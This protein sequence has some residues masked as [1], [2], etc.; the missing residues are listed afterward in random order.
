MADSEATTPELPK[1]VTEASTPDH[2]AEASTPHPPTGRRRRLWFWLAMAA[3]GLFVLATAG[4]LVAF[5]IDGRAHNGQIL[6][7][8]TLVLNE[9]TGDQLAIGGLSAAD[10]RARLQ[11]LASEHAQRSVTWTLPTDP[12]QTVTAT[13]AELDMGLDVEATLERA[14]AAGRTG[15]YITRFEAWL[16]SF[17]EPRTVDAAYFVNTSSDSPA[18]RERKDI[19]VQAPSDPA[20]DFS[21]PQGAINFAP[22]QTGSII[23]AADVVSQVAAAANPAA[24]SIDA[25]QVK[26]TTTPPRFNHHQLT[27]QVD[28]I[29]RQTERGLQVTSPTATHEFS[30]NQVRRWLAIELELDPASELNCETLP[31]YPSDAA[32]Q[33]TVELANPQEFHAELEWRFWVDVIPGTFGPIVV[34]DETPTAPFPEAGFRCCDSFDTDAVLHAV[35]DD[36][37]ETATQP[38]IEVPFRQDPELL[39]DFASE[40]EIQVIVG[41]F[42]TMHKPNESRVT[43]IQRFADLLRG[44]IIEPGARLSLNEHVGERTEENGFVEAGAINKGVFIESVGGGISQF[45]TTFF[46]AAFFAGLEFLEYQSHSLYL[47]RYPYGREATISWPYVDLAV[48]NTTPYPILIWTSYTDTSITVTMYSTK[49]IEVEQTDQT[50]T[51][52]GECDLVTSE[53]TITYEDGSERVDSVVA[54]Y[55]PEEGFTCEG[56]PYVAAPDCAPNEIG[57]DTNEDRWPDACQP[58]PPGQVADRSEFRFDKCVAARNLR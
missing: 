24:R 26:L 45:A 29:N 54:L 51:P 1:P 15:G 22:E 40:S 38:T 27:Q 53:R 42:T 56:R 18:L 2:K 43:N 44:T 14:L 46:N 34:L 55:R 35:F 20:I 39:P 49:W 28:L 10:L 7:N 31:S 11:A 6:R 23:C 25:G 33:L 47:S 30:A 4:S 32:G 5:A 8:T 3:L 36:P 19:I 52:R 48:R 9:A 17:S 57:I 12:V 21:G 58:C 37:A 50:V 41:E 13:M 16:E